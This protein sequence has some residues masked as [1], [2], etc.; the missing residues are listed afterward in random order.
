MGTR[1]LSSS[2]ERLAHR[3]GGLL[4]GHADPGQEVDGGRAHLPDD[5]RDGEGGGPLQYVRGG[6]GGADRRLAYRVEVAVVLERLGE[7]PYRV[8]EVVERLGDL[9][10]DVLVE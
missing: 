4:G 3:A 5:D 7:R 9:G 6:P 2:T 10:R 1:R 8:G